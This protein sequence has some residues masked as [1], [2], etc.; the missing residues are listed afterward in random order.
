MALTKKFFAGLAS[1][2]LAVRPEEGTPEREV[3]AQMVGITAANLATANTAFN[4]RRFY[5]ACG[6]DIAA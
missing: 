6:M 5:E 3:W 4:F 1:D 2:Y